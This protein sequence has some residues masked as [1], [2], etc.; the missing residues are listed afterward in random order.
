[1]HHTQSLRRCFVSSMLLV[2]AGCG[3]FR[4]YSVEEWWRRVIEVDAGNF[5]DIKHFTIQGIDYSHHFR[6][7]FGDRSDLDAII[8]KHRL[9]MESESRHFQEELLL[10]T[11]SLPFD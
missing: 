4:G 10:S 9:E 6:F 11:K 1:M 8:R 5:T 7:A 3:L 2:V